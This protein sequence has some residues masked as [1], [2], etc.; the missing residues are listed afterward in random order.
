MEARKELLLIFKEAINNIV[1]HAH[2]RIVTVAASCTRTL[3]QLTVEDNG[4]G[5]P[6]TNETNGNGLRNMKHRAGKIC[7]TIRVESHSGKGT[8][9]RI[10][11]PVT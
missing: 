8:L 10:E 7:G 9:V 6:G 3:L 2:A 11:V 4:S 1:K 5:L